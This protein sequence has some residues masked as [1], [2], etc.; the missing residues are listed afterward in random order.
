MFR[1]A[2][3]WILLPLERTRLTASL[4]FLKPAAGFSYIHCRD[5]QKNVISLINMSKNSPKC[6]NTPFEIT[7]NWL[8]VFL[9]FISKRSK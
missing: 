5:I 3:G 9:I 2:A 1:R 4:L 7:L 8:D 6:W